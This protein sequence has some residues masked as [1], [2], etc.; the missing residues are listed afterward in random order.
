MLYSFEA[1]LKSKLMD[2]YV[3][4]GVTNSLAWIGDDIQIGNVCI[5]TGVGDYAHYINRPTS[6]NDL[7]GVG[8]FLLMCAELSDR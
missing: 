2:Y 3:V 4:G 6:V 5:G 7:H 8:A 1:E